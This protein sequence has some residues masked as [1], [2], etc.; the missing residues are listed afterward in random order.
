MGSMDEVDTA[1][2]SQ[3]IAHLESKQQLHAD[4]YMIERSSGKRWFALCGIFQVLWLLVCTV[5]IAIICFKKIPD[6]SRETNDRF[7][8][9]S[10]MVPVGTIRAWIPDDSPPE[11]DHPL[12]LDLKTIYFLY[13][14]GSCAMEQK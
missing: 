6:L 13:K 12:T 1:Y 2:M 10:K 9:V 3:R 14:V 5:L 8:T 7:Q 4:L 11:G